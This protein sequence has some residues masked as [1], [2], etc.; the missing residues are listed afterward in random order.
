MSCWPGI[1]KAMIN[2]LF[3]ERGAV[4]HYWLAAGSTAQMAGHQ[5]FS[6][7]LESPVY[8]SNKS[9]FSSDWANW[10]VE[11][12]EILSLNGD[13]SVFYGFFHVIAYSYNFTKIC[14]IFSW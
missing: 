13:F 2:C 6:I 14:F 4:T 10:Q 1:G 11:R 3:I 7:G 9:N 12:Y 8:C 5:W